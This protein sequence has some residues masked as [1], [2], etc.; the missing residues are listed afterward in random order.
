MNP[1]FRQPLIAIDAGEQLG[2]HH[3]VIRL[4]EAQLQAGVHFVRSARQRA[5]A[6]RCH[7]EQRGDVF[8]GGGGGEGSGNRKTSA[9]VDSGA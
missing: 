6:W 2:S 7:L 5:A 1:Q 3:V 4:R 9:I 8:L